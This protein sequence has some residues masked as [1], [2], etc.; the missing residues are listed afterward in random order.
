MKILNELPLAT[1]SRFWR[2]GQILQGIVMG[3][4]LFFAMLGLLALASHVT[5]FRYQG[6]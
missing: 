2:A 5:V 1:A 4:L 6:Y 3:C